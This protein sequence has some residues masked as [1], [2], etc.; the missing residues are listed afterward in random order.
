MSTSIQKFNVLPAI[1]EY[2][3]GIFLVEN[4]D[5][6][7]GNG[8]NSIEPNGTV[9]LTLSLENSVSGQYGLEKF[10]AREGQLTYVGMFER[11]FQIAG[12]E[13]KFTRFLTIELS[14]L[15]AYRLLKADQQ[16]HVNSF[17][18][19]KDCNGKLTRELEEILINEPDVDRKIFH[20]QHY[21]LKAFFASEDDVIFD[22]C[23]K[24]I[25][26]KFG[27]ITVKELEKSTGYSSRWLNMKF[28]QQL[29]FSPKLYASIVR[30]KTLLA[31]ISV[32]KDRIM[33]DKI[34]LDYYYDQAHF[35]REFK[36]YSGMTPTEF[37]MPA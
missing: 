17:C 18:V 21:F 26:G 4:E 27:N 5:N 34:Y 2:V 37:F 10:V 3:R 30:F 6:I 35:I 23:V 25:Q 31:H 28:K 29:G 33:D 12:L 15:G 14:P 24:Q 11:P 16:E 9:K 7:F 13:K 32:G 36:R 8:M 20:L 19:L 22:Y 1:R